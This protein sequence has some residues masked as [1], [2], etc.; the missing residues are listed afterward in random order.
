MRRL[1]ILNAPHPGTFLRELRQLR[2]LRRSW[3]IAFFQLPRLPE[4]AIARNDFALIRAICQGINQQEGR[5]VMTAEDTERFVAAIARPGALTA[6]IDYYRALVRH[7]SGAIGPIR[8]ITA[9]TLVL[10]GERDPALS[11]H[12]L[13]GLN[14]WV[15]QLEVRRFTAAG[16]WLNQERPEEVN[17]ALL[18]FLGG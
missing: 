6:A 3:Y 7:G 18:A 16:H 15:T 10:W 2:Q 11:I 4:Q 13:D 8:P 5:E 1:A 17:D 14:Q 12:L 9:P